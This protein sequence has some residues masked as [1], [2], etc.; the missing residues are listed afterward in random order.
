MAIPWMAVLQIVPWK[1]V[2][3]NAP[4][5]ADGAKKLW[6]VMGKKSPT[7]NADV[8]SND[9]S[10][11]D[12]INALRTQLAEAEASLA[13]LQEQMLASSELIKSL[14]DQ[15]TQLIKRVE[16]NRVRIFWLAVVM[17]IS[18][19]VGVIWLLQTNVH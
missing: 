9:S 11:T 15:N 1:D 10:D 7:Q 6:D 17:V 14:A 19:V 5:V 18:V 8:H 4:K 12:P 13:D 3:N 2:I 16:L